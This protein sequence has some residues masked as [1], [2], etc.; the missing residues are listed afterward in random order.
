MQKTEALFYQ[1][2]Q[3]IVQVNVT[4]YSLFL[5]RNSSFNFIISRP[6]YVYFFISI[7]DVVFPDVFISILDD[8][9]LPFPIQETTR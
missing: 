7:T 1:L 2:V 5:L 3:I 8:V 9:M 6:N 4:I